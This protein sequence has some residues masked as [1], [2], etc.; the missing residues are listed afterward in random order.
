MIRFCAQQQGGSVQPGTTVIVHCPPGV[1]P[2]QQL[3]VKIGD[4]REYDIIVPPTVKEGQPFSVQLQFADAAQTAAA[5]AAAAS[6]AA[7]QAQAQAAAAQAAAA[8]NK[9][10]SGA[11][12]GRSVAGPGGVG[13]GPGGPGGP[14]GGPS[15]PGGAP[16][17]GNGAFP[18]PAERPPE[19]KLP[20]WKVEWSSKWGRWYW[21]H[22][23]SRE[24]SWKDPETS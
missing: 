22:T 6:A 14:G 16:G 5:A 11:V 15:G 24:T 3:R 1:K 19:P 18:A 2:G 12:P 17:G 21:W 23:D 13:S 4:G 7:A 9:G 8:G 20:G 10:P